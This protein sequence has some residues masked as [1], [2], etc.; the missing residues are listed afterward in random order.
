MRQCFELDEAEEAA[1]P[2]DAV[3]DAKDVREP[4]LLARVFLEREQIVVQSVEVLE[5]LDQEVPDQLLVVHAGSG[6]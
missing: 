1:R 2:F 6:E 4:V 5:R 3:D